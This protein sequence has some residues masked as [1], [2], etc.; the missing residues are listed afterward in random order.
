MDWLRAAAWQAAVRSAG[1]AARRSACQTAAALLLLALL[2]PPA[3]AADL[4]GAPA[5]CVVVDAQNA[6]FMFARGEAA[7]GLYPQ[8]V[9][10]AFQ[11]MDTA[12]RLEAIPWSRALRQLDQAECGVAGLKRFD[13]AME[14]L[15]RDGTLDRL[16]VQVLLAQ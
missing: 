1:K 14:Q 2:A 16:V 11:Q 6:P 9:R 13:A 12:V 4:A 7:E 15:R 10:A 8:L 5:V 3:Q